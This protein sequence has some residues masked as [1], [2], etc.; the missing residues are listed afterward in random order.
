MI[1]ALFTAQQESHEDIQRHIIVAAIGMVLE[2]M[3]PACITI[4]PFILFS[5]GGIQND[6]ICSLRAFRWIK[7]S[8]TK[9]PETE[10]P[11]YISLLCGWA[12]S[13]SILWFLKLQKISS[14]ILQHFTSYDLNIWLWMLFTTS[15]YLQ[16]YHPI[17][18]IMNLDNTVYI[19]ISRGKLVLSCSLKYNF[20]ISSHFKVNNLSVSN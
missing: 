10:D 20:F 16:F 13:I 15:I 1:T 11:H 4:L 5:S 8:C 3:F 14:Y 12:K 18:L 6:W 17:V 2:I 19:E 9:K 7:I